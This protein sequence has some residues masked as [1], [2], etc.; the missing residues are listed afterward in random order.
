MQTPQ[1]ELDTVTI[2]E[3]LNEMLDPVLSSRRT[4]SEP[5]KQLAKCS[6]A[7]QDFALHWLGVIISTGLL[8]TS[9]AAGDSSPRALV[10]H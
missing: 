5:A 7:Q 3:R 10:D 8:Y 4:A 6:R 1:P 9:D 2:E